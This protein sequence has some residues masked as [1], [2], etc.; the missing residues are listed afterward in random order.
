MPWQSILRAELPQIGRVV[1][2]AAVAWE[3]AVQLGATQPPIYAAFV[4]LLTLPEGPSPVQPAV[5]G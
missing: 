2:V 1:I 4:P 5:Q 3:V